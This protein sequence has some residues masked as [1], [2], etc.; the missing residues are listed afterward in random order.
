MIMFGIGELLGCFF[1]G[2]IVDKFGSRPATYV[3][4]VIM[5][6]MG[7]ITVLYCLRYEFG[8]LAYLMCF[9]WGFQ[10]SAINT[11]SQEILG[12]EFN[13]NSE[14]FSNYNILQCIACSIFQVIQIAVYDKA[15]YT[16]YSIFVGALGVLCCANTL[17]FKFREHDRKELIDLATD[18]NQFLRNNDYS[19]YA[20]EL[21]EFKRKP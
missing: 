21:D 2:Y 8:V 20:P 15:G 3:N 5:G 12:F 13:N 10:D 1:I 4:I 14:P 17:R 19:Y 11:H 9:L 7:A 6:S 18:P 16:M